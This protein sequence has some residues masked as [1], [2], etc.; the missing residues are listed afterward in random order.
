M[1]RPAR[2]RVIVAAM[3][4]FRGRDVLRRDSLLSFHT[5]LTS[6]CISLRQLFYE[7]KKFNLWTCSIPKPVH[8]DCNL[9]DQ[10]PTLKVPGICRFIGHPFFINIASGL[11]Y[12]VSAGKYISQEFWV[13][14]IEQRFHL[15]YIFLTHGLVDKQCAQCFLPIRRHLAFLRQGRSVW[16]NCKQLPPLTPSPHL[17]VALYCR[18]SRPLSLKNHSRSFKDRDPRRLQQ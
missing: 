13:W 6:C 10:H 17:C 4:A 5:L 2:A 8:A 18:H 14:I 3:L 1:C 12:G 9:L 7:I 11:Q 16:R 15:P